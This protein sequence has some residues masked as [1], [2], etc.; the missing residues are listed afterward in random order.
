LTYTIQGYDGSAIPADLV[1]TISSASPQAYSTTN[2]YKTVSN[3][4]IGNDDKYV[5]TLVITVKD[6]TSGS[7]SRLDN[8]LLT[9]PEGGASLLY[10]LL[11]GSACF[12]AMFLAS[13]GRFA[14]LSAA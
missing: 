10:L 5:N 12:G 13:R 14:K 11:A 3:P 1:Y 9:I 2:T 8:L 4:N 6:G 7:Y